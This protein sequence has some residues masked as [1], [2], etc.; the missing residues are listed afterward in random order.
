MEKIRRE[1]RLFWTR[2]G[3]LLLQI[4]GV[5]A[6]IILVIQGLNQYT[7]LQNKE[8]SKKMEA[9]QEQ[10]K[11]EQI[12]RKKNG[13]YKSL[14][15]TFI[16]YC[17]NEKI[18]EA[19]NM[20]SETCKQEKYLTITNF[21]E[22]YINKVFD[23]KKDCEITLQENNIFKIIFWEDLLQAGTIANRKQI[24]DYYMIEEDVLGNKTIYI[25]LYHNI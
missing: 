14:I 5:I 25:N 20:L 22:N 4:I 17:N 12:Q 24:E 1:I 2:N 3:K 7:I 11:Q 6:L 21:K 13:E 18:D 10:R 16:N 15:S 9:T 8:K 19:Y 23:R